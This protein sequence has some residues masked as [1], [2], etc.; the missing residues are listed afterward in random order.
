MEHGTKKSRREIISRRTTRMEHRGPDPRVDA[1]VCPCDIERTHWVRGVHAAAEP[2]DSEDVYEQVRERERDR[3]RLLHSRESPER[4]FAVVLLCADSALRC[5]IRQRVHAHV[6]AVI[7]ARPERETKCE[8]LSAQWA[9]VGSTG[10]PCALL[11]TS[12]KFIRTITGRGKSAGRK[13]EKAQRKRIKTHDR[14][15][16]TRYSR[17]V[18]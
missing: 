12:L 10:L 7:C 9:S 14:N 4:P 5:E 17:A 16:P 3:S 13:Y 11:E 6:L 18:T 15:D 2:V 1:D 8:R